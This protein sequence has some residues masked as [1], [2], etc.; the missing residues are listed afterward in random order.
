MIFSYGQ[1]AAAVVLSGASVA[2]APPPPTPAASPTP[3]PAPVFTLAPGYSYSQTVI[4]G[5][6]LP[7]V[8]GNLTGGYQFTGTS[9]SA[10]GL[11]GIGFKESYTTAGS[12]VYPVFDFTLVEADTESV[13]IPGLLTLRDGG[14]STVP[15]S[16]PTDVMCSLD[17]NG[18]AGCDGLAGLVTG[19]I[20]GQPFTMVG[21]DFPT[22]ELPQSTNGSFILQ[23]TASG[24]GAFDG[25]SVGGQI[26]GGIAAGPTTKSIGFAAAG[27]VVAGS[28][29][30]SAYLSV[31]TTGVTACVDPGT[32]AVCV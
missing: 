20:L 31:E 8:A 11:F 25:N 23:N 19:A 13:I 12:L 16:Q 6:T 10:T 30:G 5:Q 17:T 18:K 7:I 4:D 3:T 1:V 14:L 28:F 22:L 9:F 26:G 21:G 29:T 15:G 24:G 2:A 27:T 32:A